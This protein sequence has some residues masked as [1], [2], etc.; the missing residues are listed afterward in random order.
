[1]S[2]S[3]FSSRFSRSSRLAQPLQP[4]TAAGPKP[5]RDDL[6]HDPA[7]STHL[8]EILSVLQALALELDTKDKELCPRCYNET[9]E[10]IIETC[11]AWLDNEEN[12]DFPLNPRTRIN[13]IF[14]VIDEESG[15]ES[16]HTAMKVRTVTEGRWFRDACERFIS[17]VPVAVWIENG[18]EVGKAFRY[19][20]EMK[21][22]L[23]YLL[24]G[25]TFSMKH[26]LWEVEVGQFADKTVELLDIIANQ[27][28]E[29]FCGDS[30]CWP[31]PDFDFSADSS[32][33]FDFL[34]G[35]MVKKVRKVIL[36]ALGR[37]AGLRLL[38]G[39]TNQLVILHTVSE[40]P[41]VKEELAM[42]KEE[43]MNW[44]QDD[45]AD[46]FFEW[47]GGY[48]LRE[49]KKLL[50]VPMCRL[51]TKMLLRELGLG[52]LGL[53]KEEKEEE[54]GSMDVDMNDVD[55]PPHPCVDGPRSFHGDRYF[56]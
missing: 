29:R 37:A 15:P 48:L 14:G 55:E 45:C 39:G 22:K 5:I 49:G 18:M 38:A 32:E 46:W 50:P 2:H 9:C 10:V 43:T 20:R 7:Y 36:A 27:E 26:L 16:L 31:Y 13:D 47:S 19:Q 12:I 42:L 52:E 53:P 17:H 11:K 40:L 8:F 54:A 6:F 3:F 1:M 56:E 30:L 21:V 4:E 24:I 33:L 34:L 23:W 44:W 35:K 41:F 28:D 25:G 51:G